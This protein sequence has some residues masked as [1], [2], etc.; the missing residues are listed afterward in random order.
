MPDRNRELWEKKFERNVSRDNR[1]RSKLK[2]LGWKSLV[3]WECELYDLRE[4][5]LSS[6]LRAF[7]S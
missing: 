7:L 4:A 2:S 1:V 5:E 6:R 3:I